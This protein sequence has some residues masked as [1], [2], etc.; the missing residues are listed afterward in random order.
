[1]LYLALTAGR[2]QA[3]PAPQA[4]ADGILVTFREPAAGDGAK[5]D[6]LHGQLGAKL[7]YRARRYPVDFVR[8][9]LPGASTDPTALRRLC[10]RYRA[11]GEVSDCRLNRAL[12]PSRD[13]HAQAGGPPDHE[14]SPACSLAEWDLLT[15]AMA[16]TFRQRQ[17]TPLWAQTQTGS[18]LARTLLDRIQAHAGSDLGAVG[19]AILDAGF[20]L[21]SVNGAVGADIDRSRQS[22]D[23]SA[24]RH[25]WSRDRNTQRRQEAVR[26]NAHGTMVANLKNDP[27]VGTAS[28]TR[29]DRMVVIRDEQGVLR[30]ADGVTPGSPAVLNLALN[31]GPEGLPPFFNQLARDT[32]IVMSAGNNYPRPLGQAESQLDAILVGSSD[33]SGRN[34]DFS[35]PGEPVT[36]LAPADHWALSRQGS[37]Y[38]RF[39]GT[40]AATPQ[41]EGAL[42]MAIAVLGHAHRP[43][44][45]AAQARQL[46]KLTALPSLSSHESPQADGA[47][48]LDVLRVAAV[49]SRLRA[50]DWADQDDA[51]R[52]RLLAMP[53]LLDFTHPLN[54]EDRS[55]WQSELD[56]QTAL[57]DGLTKIASC[58]TFAE[59]LDSLNRAFL[60]SAR[61]GASPAEQAIAIRAR[62]ALA[63]AYRRLG[64]ETNAVF[65]DNFDPAYFL[66]HAPQIVAGHGQTLPAADS[67]ERAAAL[68]TLGEV[69]LNERASIDEPSRRTIAATLAAAARDPEPRVRAT[70]AREAGRLPAADGLPVLSAILDRDLG[71]V[72]GAPVRAGLA[73]GA[74]RLAGES[75]FPILKRLIEAGDDDS[76]AIAAG[77][78]ADL[79]NHA[80]ALLQA[81]LTHPDEPTL[82]AVV[83]S[84]ARLPVTGESVL[85]ALPASASAAVHAAAIEAAPHVNGGDR[86]LAQE[87]KGS[88]RD[89]AQLAITTAREWAEAEAKKPPDQ[90][91]TGLIARLRAIAGS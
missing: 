44:L 78:A 61:G 26:G 60:L 79:P 59:G 18:R 66:A 62:T 38:A 76:R 16:R 6:R 58:E 88:D 46:L 1:M 73:F 9:L 87:A 35:S 48:I 19:V 15:P 84:A 53:E 25:P 54:G 41:V 52:D 91:D 37:R 34:S 57:Q 51:G 89:R 33:P 30:F 71:A 4:V 27:V 67:R 14:A 11:S 81:A 77:V 80:V 69:F 72:D 68:R 56:P 5:R 12:T 24:F 50:L 17:L 64:M 8:P 28:H 29:I 70:A 7:V 32:L 63:A 74:A 55:W 47:G 43:A 45:T 31:P 21:N 40:S 20:E 85:E 83:A 10:A 2:A 42:D 49:A 82:L 13:D 86:L 39:A 22:G 65:Y 36:V 3:S 75:G 90:R 23:L